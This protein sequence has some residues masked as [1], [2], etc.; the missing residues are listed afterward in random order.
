[1]K[2]D[3][4]T[5]EREVTCIRTQPRQD[6]HKAI[7]HLGGKGWLMTRWQVTASIDSGGGVFYLLVGGRRASIQVVAGNGE[8]Y[9][10]SLIDNQWTDDLLMLPECRANIDTRAR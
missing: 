5:A 8:P 7:T 2:R 3:D 1:M 10:R 4:A 6:R 9:L